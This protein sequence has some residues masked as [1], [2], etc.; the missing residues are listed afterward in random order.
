M[1][2][3]THWTLRAAPRP[4][5]RLLS[6]VVVLL[7]LLQIACKSAPPPP[8][9]EALATASQDPDVQALLDRTLAAALAAPEDKEA[10]GILGQALEANGFFPRAITAYEHAIA[11][12]DG[13]PLPFYRVAMCHQAQGDLAAAAD[14]FAAAAAQDPDLPSVHWR[15][16]WALLALGKLDQAEASLQ[17]A[18]DRDPE[19]SAPRLGLARIDLERG[20][21]T[22]AAARL[23]P[24]VANGTADAY[25]RFLLATAYRQLGR[26]EEAERLL[27]S[28]GSAPPQPPEW[29]DP[30]G[31]ALQSFRVSYGNRSEEAQKLLQTGQID[32]AV[33]LL[34]ALHQQRPSDVLAT[35][36]LAAGYIAAGRLD[37]ALTLLEG[38]EE[39]HGDRYTVMMNLAAVHLMAGRLD[40]ALDYGEKAAAID[41]TK[42]RTQ[43]LIGIIWLN[44]GEPR[45][46]LE[47]LERAVRLAPQSLSSI[48]ALAQAQVRSDLWASARDSFTRAIA[49]SPR[50]ADLYLGLG[51]SQVELGASDEARR[52]LDQ[53][54]ALG[55][56]PSGPQRA[57]LDTLRTRLP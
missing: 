38:L 51:R 50:R 56:P 24:G 36:N 54:E 3:T 7:L 41:P 10:W 29:P 12:G 5:R 8:T 16:G 34:E 52:A 42:P 4:S 40:Q 49:L 21:P 17:R 31:E 46:A 6:T 57:E 30:L 37:Q 47:P 44:R 33:P 2:N 39:S 43:E 45:K 25:T 26:G 20:H 9:A 55:L 18:A 32:R 11:I 13:E 15:Q 23:E 53:A 27:A 28:L 19:H 48:T 35:T 22:E 14:A 1:P